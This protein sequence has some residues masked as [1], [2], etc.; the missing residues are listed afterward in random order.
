MHIAPPRKLLKN[1]VG[2]YSL[3]AV[4]NSEFNFLLDD[5]ESAALLRSIDW[6]KHSLGTPDQWSTTLKT[7]LGIIFASRHPMF[8]WWGPELIQFY[9][10]AYVPSFG[11]GKHPLAMGQK[12]KD[13]WPEIWPIISP[14]IEDVLKK[15]KASWNVDQLVP[16][17]RNGKIEDVYW[18]YGY[19]PVV[20]ERGEIA[21]VLV[22]CTETTQQVLA[23]REL[24]R[25]EEELRSARQ[26][27]ENFLL[28]APIGITILSGP[29]HVFTFVNPKYMSL[30][31]G[32]RPATDLL[33]KSVREALPELAGQGFLEILAGVYQTGTSYTG[34]KQ[35]ISLFQGNGVEKEM[36]VNFT[37]QAKRDK[38]GKI[39]GILAVIYEVTD[40]VNE[41]KEIELLAN[42]LRS[43][44]VS[45]DT[46]L[47]IASHELNT[48]LTSLKL[49][50]QMG[51][52]MLS[53][54]DSGNLPPEKVAKLL[55]NTLLQA[56]RLGRLV[57]DMLDVS[58]ISSGKLTMNLSKTNLSSLTQD[59]LERFTPQFEQVGCELNAEISPDL[60]IS[61]D[62]SRI[63]QV[64]TN[65][66]TNVIKYAPGKP[67]HAT[68]ER[69][70]NMGKISFQDHGR[71]IPSHHQERI[72]GRFERAATDEEASG[73]GLGLYICKQIVQQHGG[74]IY[75]ES[76]P[77]EG[78]KFSVEL[79]LRTVEN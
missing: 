16:I 75:V 12:G 65:L 53:K 15:G 50:T 71:G 22:V 54:H 40:A 24:R 29:E 1:D 42:N 59:I 46:F 11:K 52:R 36:Y 43:A 70:G 34:A 10:D 33:G 39:D 31:F 69:V 77:G 14:Q 68:L 8:L 78:S 4:K 6:S 32:G 23:T 74:R 55:D 17:F 5:G 47:G 67:V 19:S 58:R 37:Y 13:C 26:E 79:P 9:N 30:I 62:A 3:Q 63:E 28:Q 51:K 25:S 18:T 72:F 48:P 41:Q 7:T 2:T 35:R 64:L 60:Q 44:I 56:E 20:D 57:D 27:V 49:Q 76:N 73:L 61:A 38:N 66:I 21:G 45:R